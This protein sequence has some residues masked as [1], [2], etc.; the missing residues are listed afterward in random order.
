MKDP[1]NVFDYWLLNSWRFADDRDALTY[2][3]SSPPLKDT[4][5]SF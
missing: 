3:R 4:F 2:A 1:F 5:V